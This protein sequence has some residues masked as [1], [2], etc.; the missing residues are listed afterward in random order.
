VRAAGARAARHAERHAGGVD[1][2]GGRQAGGAADDA[3]QADDTAPSA[4]ER[5]ASADEVGP[6]LEE[7]PPA[8]GPLANLGTAVVV[9]AIGVAGMVGSW[10][11]GL[12]TPEAPRAGTWPFLV[13][14]VVVVLGVA[15]GLV[16]RN[17]TDAEAFS[18]SSWA[19]V[20]GLASMLGFVAL[21]GVIGFEIP[22]ALLAFGWLRFLGGEGWVKSIITSLAVV[23]AFYVIFVG[24][25]GVPIPHMF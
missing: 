23:V 19:V 18:R 3:G 8:A 11:M 9:V 5:T 15:L 25:L 1:E 16:G 4:D 14:T 21:I 20:A 13:S 7:R 24:L 10:S 22:A 6:R 12:G 17:S 2:H